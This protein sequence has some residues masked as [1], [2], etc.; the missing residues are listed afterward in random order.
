MVY[1]H[2]RRENSSQQRV[3]DTFV[4]NLSTQEVGYQ[5][6]MEALGYVGYGRMEADGEQ[7]RDGS[8]KA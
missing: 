7:G 6:A 3:S 5:A 2:H 1:C 8:P 4:A